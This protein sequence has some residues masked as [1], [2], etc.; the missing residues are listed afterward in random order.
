MLATVDW[1]KLLYPVKILTYCQV[2]FIKLKFAVE[3]ICEP[4]ELVK[5]IKEVPSIET[6][7]KDPLLNKTPE[8]G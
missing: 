8:I 2:F 7:R 4:S 6:E 5:I 3:L 1:V